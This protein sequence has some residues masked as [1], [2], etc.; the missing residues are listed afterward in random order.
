MK[1]LWMYGAGKDPSANIE[2][3]K[4]LG[5]EAVVGGEETAKAAVEAGLKAYIATGAYRGPDFKGEEFKARDLFGK[6]QDWFGSTCPTRSEVRAYN[7]SQIRRLAKT[8]GIEGVIIDGARFA[9][10]ASGET[11]EAFFTCFCPRCMAKA[12]SMGFDSELMKKTGLRLYQLLHEGAGARGSLGL[13]LE[14]LRNLGGIRQIL[15]FRRKAT[16]EHLVNFCKAVREVNPKLQCGIFIFAPCLAELV[17]QSYED[18]NA[19]MDIIAPMLYRNYSDRPG[20]ACLNTEVATLWEILE[21]SGAQRPRQLSALKEL[22]GFSVEAYA[23]ADGATLTPGSLREKGFS[24][25]IIREETE[26]ARKAAPKAHLS[27][28]LQLC[29][30]Q[31]EASCQAAFAGGASSVDFFLY[32]DEIVSSAGFSQLS[33]LGGAE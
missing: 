1:R 33:F 26:R 7:L 23:A 4:A 2:K 25:E 15:D 22:L 14:L 19:Q 29:D 30:D 32:D 3:L 5:F 27:P 31:L 8:P 20:P 18:M 16:T 10:P 28:I 21:E 17:G 11:S 6:P 13:R 12:E 9:S 24:P